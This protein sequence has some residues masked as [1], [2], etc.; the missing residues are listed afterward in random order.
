MTE[1]TWVSRAT[2]GRFASASG[3][4]AGSS[5]ASA[6]VR[7]VS[8]VPVGFAAP[9]NK[10]IKGG[11]EALN[12]MSAAVGRMWRKPL[13]GHALSGPIGVAFRVIFGTLR[14]A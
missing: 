1:D 5:A 3:G 9:A 14:L 12:Q 8:R 2:L 7:S 6:L 13:W 10:E 11:V 4:S